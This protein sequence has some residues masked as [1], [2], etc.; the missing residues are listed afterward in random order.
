MQS[1]TALVMTAM[2]GTSHLAASAPSTG[3]PRV[4]LKNARY[5]G[6][7]VTVML[8][9]RTAVDPTGDVTKRRGEIATARPSSFVRIT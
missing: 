2:Y 8:N 5:T 6:D 3:H 4:M 1:V 7:Q 9:N